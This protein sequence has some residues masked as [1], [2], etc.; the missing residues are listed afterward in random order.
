MTSPDLVSALLE[1]K[2]SS[3]T[4]KPKGYAELLAKLTQSPGAFH[5]QQAE[6][7]VAYIDS[8]L[9]SSLGIIA[10]RPLLTTLIQALASS[11]SEVKVRVG[12]HLAT[13][14][15]A[16]L[17]SFEEQ[18]ARVREILADGYEAEEEWSQ[19]AK[20][21]QGIQLDSTQRT[22]PDIAKVQTWIRI[23]RCYLEDDDT[24]AAEIALNKIKNSNAAVQVLQSSPDLQ[25]HYQIS[26]ARILDSRRDFLNASA[27]YLNVSFNSSVAEEDRLQALSAAIKTAILA[28]AGPHRSRTLSKLYKDER[29]SET[30][31][32][33]I[34]ESMFLD[35]L[36]APAEVEAFAAKLAPHQLASTADGSTVLSKAVVE[37]N[38]IAASRLYENISTAAL[39]K[40]LGLKDSKEETAA[41]KAE[42]Y[43]ARMVEQGRL[44]AEIDQIDGIITFERI[45]G[46]ALHG[47]DHERRI[48][49]FDVQGLVEDVE[50]CAA[51]VA[52]AF[53][54]LA[55]PPIIH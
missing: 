40:L 36:L 53:P 48:W 1:L 26:Q 11:P 52:E 44:K 2:D 42:D 14:L 3:A 7:L 20:A 18:D 30:E 13:V 10:I 8:L 45:T 5:H 27:E 41:E 34:L 55:T 22:V 28:P 23:V 47:P 16:Q 37:H 54:V 50:R 17:A 6:N 49:D 24:V 39:A 21:L 9:A 4:Q 31:E 33:G 51:A 46:V 29:S 19:A 32:Y 38:L 25:L 15:Q 12:A 43:A 35:R